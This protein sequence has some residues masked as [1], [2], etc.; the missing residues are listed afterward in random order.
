M[1]IGLV[2]GVICYLTVLLKTKLGYN[3]VLD[4]VGVHG[5]GGFF[6]ALATGIFCSTAANPGGA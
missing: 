4:V 6:G 3:E 5:V 1:I 2:A